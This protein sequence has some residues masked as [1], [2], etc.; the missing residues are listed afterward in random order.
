[1]I[2]VGVVGFGYWG[3]NLV[4]NFIETEGATVSWVVDEKRERLALAAERFPGVKTGSSLEELLAS[5]DVDAV[6]IATPVSTH[7]QLAR[8]T[9]DSGRHVLVEKPLAG[10]R[11]D[12]EVLIEVAERRGLTLMVDHTFPYTGAVRKIKEIVDE[13]LLGA[14]NYYDSVRVNLGLFQHDVSVVWDLAVHDLAIIDFLFEDRIEAVSAT[15]VSHL[16]GQPENIAYI[17][18]FL[19]G[20]KT[21]HVHA[22]WLAPVKVRQTLI[23]GTKSMILYDDLEPTEKVKIYDSGVTLEEAPEAVHRLRVGY[24]T[25][26][27]WAPKL[28]NHEA[29]AAVAR[30]FLESI[31]A[32]RKPLM[33][34]QAGL[35]VVRSLEAATLSM[36]R[37]GAPVTV[38]R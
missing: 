38:E 17:T 37:R 8:Q 15:G 22:N 33:D 34:G 28:D 12:C 10:R 35:R 14:V 20:N 1:M 26:D 30:D 5:P 25:G 7:F 27:M 18:F 13:G 16:D 29:L 32:G 3:P 9:L 23:G 36:S 31:S 11:Q 21:A 6:A 19:E 4:R 2:R 24:R